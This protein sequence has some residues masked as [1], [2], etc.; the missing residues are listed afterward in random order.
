MGERNGRETGD[1]EERDRG[2]MREGMR[3]GNE[4]ERER[5]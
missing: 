3:E 1:K 4:S 2:G 5:D